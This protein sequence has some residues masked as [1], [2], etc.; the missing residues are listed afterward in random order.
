MAMVVIPNGFRKVCGCSPAGPGCNR[1]PCKGG[2]WSHPSRQSR[3]L[4]T[5]GRQGRKA[6]G[7]FSP[8]LLVGETTN[9]VREQ[10]PTGGWLR[11]NCLSSSMSGRRK[12]SAACNECGTEGDTRT[13]IMSKSTPP[14]HLST[15][16]ELPFGI[17]AGLTK[18]PKAGGAAA[19]PRCPWLR[20]EDLDTIEDRSGARGAERNGFDGSYA[21]R[22]FR[23]IPW[24]YPAIHPRDNDGAGRSLRY[25]DCWS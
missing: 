5:R 24:R 6:N 16:H 13:P 8:S 19:Q 20:W 21:G 10:A 17:G 9:L 1:K 4:P 2:V 22:R 18:R 7:P 25:G 3:A 12:R 23:S 14:H 15:R 11:E